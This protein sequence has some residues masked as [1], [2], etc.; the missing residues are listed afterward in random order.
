MSISKYLM[1][2]RRL[3]A[4]T[5]QT[6]GNWGLERVSQFFVLPTCA[7][8]DLSFSYYYSINLKFLLLNL[9]GRHKSF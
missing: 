2:F 7:A 8:I 6:G 1:A 5:A 4:S 3:D 9:W